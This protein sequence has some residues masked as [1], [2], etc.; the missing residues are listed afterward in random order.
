LTWIK[1]R[2]CAT[3][4]QVSGHVGLEGGVPDKGLLEL[5]QAALD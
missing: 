1:A 5:V 3:D 4:A 2:P